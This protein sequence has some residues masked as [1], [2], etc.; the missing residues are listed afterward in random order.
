VWRGA[1]GKCVWKNEAWNV[2]MGSKLS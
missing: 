2:V 1:H